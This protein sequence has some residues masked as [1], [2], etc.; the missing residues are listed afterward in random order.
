MGDFRAQELIHSAWAFAIS[1]QQ[2][3]SLFVALLGHWLLVRVL[4]DVLSVRAHL[5]DLSWP[6]PGNLLVA[7]SRLL[8]QVCAVTYPLLGTLGVCLAKCA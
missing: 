1:D 4:G 3:A 6:V 8:N 7:G 5:P 2:D